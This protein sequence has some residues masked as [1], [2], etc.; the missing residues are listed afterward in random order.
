[1]KMRLF[2]LQDDNNKTKKLRLKRLLEGWKD[3]KKVFYY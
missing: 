3:I 1:M 2:E